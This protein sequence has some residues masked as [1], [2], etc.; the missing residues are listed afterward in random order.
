GVRSPRENLRELSLEEPPGRLERSFTAGNSTDRQPCY[1]PDGTRVI[2][3]L[4]R[5]GNLDVWE[6]HLQSRVLRRLTDSP[7]D[8]WDP[9]FS[10]DGKHLRR[11]RCLPSNHI[12][13]SLNKFSATTKLS[14]ASA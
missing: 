2:F 7:A 4:S 12:C 10:P 6:I 9:A 11:T 8:D 3:S 1:S 5:T 13:R 14:E